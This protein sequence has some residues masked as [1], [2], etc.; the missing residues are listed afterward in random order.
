MI[1]R[2]VF[3]DFRIL[4]T[5][6]GIFGNR[7]IIGEFGREAGKENSLGGIEG[8]CGVF[9][10]L[11]GCVFQ[12][13]YK[14]FQHVAGQISASPVEDKGKVLTDWHLSPFADILNF[15]ER[16]LVFAVIEAVT[17]GAATICLSIFSF[18]SETCDIIPT[19]LFP[20]VSPASA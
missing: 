3:S 2:S 1:G 18:K 19:S 5:F 4:F 10:F 11:L 20:S 6:V 15:S 12:C 8:K 16:Q 13:S 9:A 14:F 7:F 17:A